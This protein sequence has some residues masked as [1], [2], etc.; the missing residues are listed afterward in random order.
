MLGASR[1]RFI[2]LQGFSTVLRMLLAPE[3]FPRSTTGQAALLMF[4]IASSEE[5]PAADGQVCR[6]ATFGALLFLVFRSL[7]LFY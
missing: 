5:I 7:A 2:E 6:V 3:Q 4:R 1:S